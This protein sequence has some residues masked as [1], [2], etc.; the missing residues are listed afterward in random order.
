M[1]KRAL[2][3]L[4]AVS[5]IMANVHP[6]ISYAKHPAD[7]IMEFYVMTPEDINPYTVSILALNEVAHDRNLDKVKNFIV[8][9]FE[10]LNYP[11]RYGLTGTIYDFVHKD[12]K[13][14][15]TGTYDSVDGYAGMFLHLLHQYLLKTGD[16]KLIK[17]N[18]NKIEDIVYLL[19]HLQD[20]DG[21]TRAL[22]TTQEKYLMDNCEAYGGVTAY[23]AISSFLDKGN[24]KYYKEV[25][26]TIKTGIITHLYQPKKRIFAW[27][28]EKGYKST[29]R[30]DVFYPDAY[31]QL[32]PLYFNV[33]SEQPELKKHLWQT[34]EQKYGHQ[35][36]KFPIEQRII[37]EL[38]KAK[39]QMELAEP[40]ENTNY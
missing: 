15:P 26:S 28:T 34:F 16:V 23:L 10:N 3:L 1:K 31:A 21:L 7:E 38:T 29:S 9:Y 37:Y 22:T 32:F 17:A 30:W 39:M 13:R 2:L 8:W 35:K 40:I 33:L 12:G 27:A 6:E 19:S 11:D 25:Q 5:F 14:Q 18:W 20:E 24:Q 4:I 36:H